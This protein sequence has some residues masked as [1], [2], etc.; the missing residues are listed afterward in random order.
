MARFNHRSIPLKYVLRVLKFYKD[1]GLKKVTFIGG[2]PGL[3]PDFD[4]ILIAAGELGL[5]VLLNTS[6]LCFEEKES[7]AERLKHIDQVVLSYHSSNPRIQREIT[8]SKNFPERMVKLLD[9][10]ES[11]NPST[12]FTANIVLSKINL[13]DV[14]NTVNDIISRGFFKQIL[15]SFMVPEGA[16]R[17]RYKEI[18]AGLDEIRQYVP[19]LVDLAG[20]AGITI[21]FFS[22]PACVLFP[23]HVHSNDFYFDP[24]YGMGLSDENG[25]E[26]L[27]EIFIEHAG[28][29]RIRPEKCNNCGFASNKLCCGI[30]EKYYR[31]F[32]DGEISPIESDQKSI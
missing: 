15:V 9:N 18:V 20:A 26:S 4:N 27:E 25:R 13:H 3:H 28:N 12:R 24:R 11:L 29:G 21:R 10:L 22:I 6:G 14:V 8:G 31:I 17:D 5:I 16:A 2:E 19:A 1:K 7:A 30:V 32:G 23:H